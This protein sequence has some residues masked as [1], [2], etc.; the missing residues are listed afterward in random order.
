MDDRCYPEM[1]R[2]YQRERGKKLSM[3]EVRWYLRRVLY[4]WIPIHLRIKLRNL[5]AR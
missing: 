2:V 5:I 1:I 4:A 3:L